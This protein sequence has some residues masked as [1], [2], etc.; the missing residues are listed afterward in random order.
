MAPYEP[1]GSLPGGQMRALLEEALQCARRNRFDGEPPII[2][3]YRACNASFD[4]YPNTAEL[5]AAVIGRDRLKGGITESTPE[6][7]TAI[8]A[9]WRQSHVTISSNSWRAEAQPGGVLDCPDGLNSPWLWSSDPMTY[10]EDGDADDDQFY[11]ADLA[12]LESVLTRFVASGQPGAASLFVY[13]VRPETRPKFWS[14]A[15]ELSGR[16]GATLITAWVT[17]QGGN[18]NL[19]A[20][21]C[22]PAMLRPVWFPERIKCGR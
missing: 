17:H 20:V 2:S 6:K 9:V 19:A 4:H 21:L 1:C 13:A 5:L 3:A 8:E 14:F 18:R 22:S 16:I 15:D 10:H 11:R 12:R 7:C